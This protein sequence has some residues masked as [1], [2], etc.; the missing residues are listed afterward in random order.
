MAACTQ[1]PI[2]AQLADANRRLT[3]AKTKQNS[4][5]DEVRVCIAEIRRVTDALA[6]GGRYE[7]KVSEHALLRYAERVMGFDTND[8]LRLVRDRVEPTA[9]LLGDGKFPIVPGF[10]AVVK[11]RTVVTIEPA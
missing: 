3:E 1:D 2:R 5:Q 11:N 10:L 4:A 6:H 9:Y 8:V 7:L